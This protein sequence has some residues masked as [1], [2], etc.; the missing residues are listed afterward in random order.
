MRFESWHCKVPRLSYDI[1]TIC[2]NHTMRWLISCLS[3]NRK[4]CRKNV[5][6]PT[7]LDQKIST[8]SHSKEKMKLYNRALSFF[9]FRFHQWNIEFW[10]V[11]KKRPKTISAVFF[12]LRD[13]KSEIQKKLKWK[14]RKNISLSFHAILN[15]IC[16][17][18][19]DYI[20]FSRHLLFSQ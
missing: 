13:L 11:P 19:W 6:S 10:S 1:F 7:I 14:C 2:P 18:L 12:K 8:W 20:H 9:E 5:C 4:I 3:R 15:S 16:W 17:K